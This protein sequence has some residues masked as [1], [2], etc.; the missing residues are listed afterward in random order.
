VREL[1][2]P[3]PVAQVWAGALDLSGLASSERLDSYAL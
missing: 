3:Q 1:L 2:I